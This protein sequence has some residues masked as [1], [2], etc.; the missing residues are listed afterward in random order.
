MLLSVAIEVSDEGEEVG[1]KVR[2]KRK[3]KV[4]ERDQ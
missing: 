3:G 1:M 4:N 2:E